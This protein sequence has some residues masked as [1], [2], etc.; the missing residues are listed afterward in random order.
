MIEVKKF[1][2]ELCHSCIGDGYVAIT[3]TKYGAY[4]VL[5]KK[6][7]WAV[8]EPLR[9]FRTIEDIERMGISGKGDIQG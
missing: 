9:E 5:C 6:C 8:L 7:A 2:D 1:A 4:I 3:Y